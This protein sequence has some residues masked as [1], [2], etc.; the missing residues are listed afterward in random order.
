MLLTLDE[1][2]DDFESQSLSTL[3]AWSHGAREESRSVA[4]PELAPA[5]ATLTIVLVFCWYFFRT[6]S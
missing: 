6:P 3:L 1:L 4:L 5:I 2:V